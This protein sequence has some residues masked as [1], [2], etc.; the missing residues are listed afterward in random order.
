MNLALLN[1]GVLE[2]LLVVVFSIIM[3]LLPL[4][5]L[6]DIYHKQFNNR[7]HLLINLVIVWLLPVIGSLIYIFLVRNHLEE[8]ETRNWS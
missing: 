2:F 8:R 4:Y 6:F 1:L 7:N 5:C 3:S